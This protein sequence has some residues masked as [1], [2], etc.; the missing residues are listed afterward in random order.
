MSWVLDIGQASSMLGD[1]RP[2]DEGTPMADGWDLDPGEHVLW[3]GDPKIEK[4][5]G[6][7]LWM[8]A[9]NLG[10]ALVTFHTSGGLIVWHEG[11]GTV[12][13]VAGLIV[14]AVLAFAIVWI[15]RYL[16]RLSR[17]HYLLTSHRAIVQQTSKDVSSSVIRCAP[18]TTPR[19]KVK[20]RKGGK[21]GDVDWGPVVGQESKSESVPIR[22]AQALGLL[23][24]EKQQP[25]LFVEI[26]DL[27]RLL[28]VA[29]AARSSLGLTAG[30]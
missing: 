11:A 4:H 24:S 20:L 12:L 8:R 28:G 6:R 26:D 15:P 21:S 9:G 5:F 29:R 22:V 7:R 17:T 13:T 2:G 16:D 25:V 23:S 18:I 14:A 1:L 30:L 19:I 3:R 27:P 10:L